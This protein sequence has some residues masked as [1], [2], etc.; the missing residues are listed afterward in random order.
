MKFGQ[1]ITICLSLTAFFTPQKSEGQTISGVINSYHKVTAIV[2][3]T[4]NSYS[5]TGI[6]LESITGL[7]G[8]DLLSDRS[9]LLD[10]P[11]ALTRNCENA[12][13]ANV[14]PR[15]IKKTSYVPYSTVR[16]KKRA[17]FDARRAEN[18]SRTLA[19]TKA[20]R[21]SLLIEKRQ[22]VNKLRESLR[23]VL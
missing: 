2:N 5:Y 3:G 23:S 15:V 10:S 9:S 22:E 6:T 17:D 18:E 4:H 1:F 19:R 21:K 11:D 12:P 14:T 16:A 20:E 7:C 8:L 13:P